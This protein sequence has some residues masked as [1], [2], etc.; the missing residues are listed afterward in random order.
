MS[1]CESRL[2]DEGH[3]MAAQVRLS[4]K[5][6]VTGWFPNEKACIA[7]L[8]TACLHGKADFTFALFRQY[9]QSA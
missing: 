1:V 7:T 8:D 4:T 6:P 5:P 9:R 2:A 3:K